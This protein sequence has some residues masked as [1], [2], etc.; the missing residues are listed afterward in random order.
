MAQLE[1]KTQ[2]VFQSMAMDTPLMVRTDSWLMPSPQA[3][4][5]EET[6][7]LMTMSY[8]PWEKAK[9]RKGPSACPRPSLLSSLHSICLDQRGGRGGKSHI[10]VSQNLGLQ[11]RPGEVQPPPSMSLFSGPCEVW[12][13][14]WGVLQVPLLVQWQGVQQLH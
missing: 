12:E 13:R 10:W 5:L 4:V 9:V 8:G 14:R 3:L 1:A 6:P 7:T 11:R 2:C